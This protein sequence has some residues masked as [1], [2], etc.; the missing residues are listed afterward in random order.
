MKKILYKILGLVCIILGTIGIFLPILPTTPFLLLAAFLF[1][2]SSEE[3]YNWLMNHPV[4]GVYLKS[5]IKYRGI[6]KEHKI[7]AISSLW[8]GI[9]FS[10]YLVDV[11]FARIFLLTIAILVTIHLLSFRT[12]SKSDIED[13][14]KMEV[15][16]KEK[17]LIK[18]NIIISKEDPI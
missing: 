18:N 3:L 7:M 15:E 8:L 6:R 4:L 14:E 11:L 17:D 12:L 2:R 5:Y 1:L 13:I 16:L 10:V 9:L